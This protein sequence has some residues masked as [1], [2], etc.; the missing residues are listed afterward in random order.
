MNKC[1]VNKGNNRESHVLPV[2]PVVA[3]WPPA[4][5]A[6]DAGSPGACG[7]PQSLGWLL[8]SGTVLCGRCHP[9]PPH[10][11]RVVLTDSDDG[12]RWVEVTHDNP[13]MVKPEPSPVSAPSP[14]TT[15]T[16]VNTKAAPRVRKTAN[17]MT[18]M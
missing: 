15:K 13:P 6:D 5:L 10:S 18:W 14:A 17:D 12:P 9:Q 8:P 3:G 2:A 16:T 4:W 1:K 7:W 11:Q